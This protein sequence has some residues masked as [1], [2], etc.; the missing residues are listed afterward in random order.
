MNFKFKR[1][2]I[3]QSSANDRV[4]GYDSNKNLRIL[5]SFDDQNQQPQQQVVPQQ[6]KIQQQ[7]INQLQQIAQ[8]PVIQH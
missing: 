3:N 8:Q 6:Q 2:T 4:V 1:T 5:L 7:Q